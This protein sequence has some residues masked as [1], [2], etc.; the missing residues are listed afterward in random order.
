MK[1]CSIYSNVHFFPLDKCKCVVKKHFGT[2]EYEQV[3]V[4]HVRTMSEFYILFIYEI[5]LSLRN[6]RYKLN[7]YIRDC[8]SQLSARET[9]N[10]FRSPKLL[11]NVNTT[12]LSVGDM[13]LL[14]N[15][16]SQSDAVATIILRA[17]NCRRQHI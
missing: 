4:I 17:P 3:L 1:F 11:Q 7:V 6:T 10:K 2:K 14:G 8:L 13:Y 15:M 9:I 12:M 16:E 5:L